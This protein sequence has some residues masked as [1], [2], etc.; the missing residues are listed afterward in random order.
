M[1]PLE[2]APTGVPPPGYTTDLTSFRIERDSLMQ[3]S[4]I[5]SAAS[6]EHSTLDITDSMCNLVIDRDSLTGD[7]VNLSDLQSGGILVPGKKTD[8]PPKPPAH[9]SMPNWVSEM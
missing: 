7:Y 6:K 4:A 5:S 9:R 2:I 8:Q 1:H 3:S